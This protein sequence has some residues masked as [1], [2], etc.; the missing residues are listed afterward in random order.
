MPADAVLVGIG[1]VVQQG[2]FQ[3]GQQVQFAEVE[4]HLAGDQL[5]HVEQVIDQQA[6][7][8]RSWWAICSMPLIGPGT[9][10]EGAAHH[11]AEGAGDG[12][13]RV[14]SSWLTVETNSFFICSILRRSVMSRTTP[15]KRRA[16]VLDGRDR[17]LH[18][19]LRAVAA[20][21][22]Q[23]AAADTEDTSCL[24]AVAVAAM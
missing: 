17:Q 1:L 19:E 3:L 10:A 7:V 23:F 16:L 11:Q 13:Q 6:Q 15:M 22:Q 21:P 8:G 12:G 2:L 5:F 4:G 14:R 20:Q 24:A 18:V 9:S